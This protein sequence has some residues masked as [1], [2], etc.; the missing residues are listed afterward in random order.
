MSIKLN[1]NEILVLRV[2]GFDGKSYGGFQW[3]LEIGAVVEASDWHYSAN[4]DYNS[5]RNYGFCGLPWGVYHKDYFKD[6]TGLWMLLVVN[7]KEGYVYREE[8]IFK[9]GRIVYIGE[10][11]KAIEILQEMAPEGTKI[12]YAKQN[13][14][15]NVKQI[16][17]YNSDQVVGDYS[18]QYAYSKSNQVAGNYAVQ[19]SEN[20]TVQAAG[21]YSK[22]VSRDFAIQT[23]GD[24]CTQVS[25]RDSI[26]K[27][28]IFANQTTGNLSVQSADHDSFQICGK[29][30]KQIAGNNSI[31][32][33]DIG[34]VQVTKWFCEKEKK[35]KIS[36]RIVDDIIANKYYRVK[37]G[38]WTEV[39]K[40]LIP[41]KVYIESSTD[42][43]LAIIKTDSLHMIVYS[44]KAFL[45]QEEYFYNDDEYIIS[46]KSF[47]D[48]LKE[49]RLNV[50]G[51]IRTFI[52]NTIEINELKN[53][54]EPFRVYNKL[55]IS[56]TSFVIV[57]TDSLDII[58]YVK[59]DSEV[60]ILDGNLII[61]FD[62][63]Q[64]TVSNE[65]FIDF[66]K[67]AKTHVCESE[68]ILISNAIEIIELQY[69]NK[70]TVK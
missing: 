26:Q 42:K 33:A 2:C 11:E 30:C 49:A 66:L 5:S 25:W 3:P 6:Y 16:A 22:Q 68:K 29:N 65:S 4:Q 61:E 36:I 57:K 44:D 64:C 48:F 55:S 53:K 20:F 62:I 50:S 54:F 27:A 28:S 70:E 58:V 43:H 34:T 1:E 23:A 24:Y 38:I 39:K 31:Q 19:K 8:A 46:S 15:D 12:M 9:K 63:N 69:N 35:Y 32:I 21:D 67:K 41:G 18:F 45:I 40:E 7:I 59:D 56:E 60:L 14:G 37:D 10:K 47:I 52:D 17:G 13:G 51:N